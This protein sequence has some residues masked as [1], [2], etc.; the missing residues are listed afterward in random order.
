MGRQP[1][2]QNSFGDTWTKAP[3]TLMQPKKIG[4]GILRNNTRRNGYSSATSSMVE[5]SKHGGYDDYGGD[6]YDGYD[7]D[8]DMDNRIDGRRKYK[9]RY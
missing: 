8:T 2:K 7:P 3:P 1:D 9:W 5:L 6:A 4:G